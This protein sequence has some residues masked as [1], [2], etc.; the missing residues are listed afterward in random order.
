MST[1][2]TSPA[3]ASSRRRAAAPRSAR[4]DAQRAAAERF[5]RRIVQI[6]ALNSYGR[7]QQPRS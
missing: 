3:R 6:A 1:I 2:P 4:E 5:A 7:P